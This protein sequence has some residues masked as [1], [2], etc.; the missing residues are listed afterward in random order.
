[1]LNSAALTA[2]ALAAAM[3]SVFLTAARPSNH[4][5]VECPIVTPELGHSAL[6]RCAEYA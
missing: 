5:N 3:A 2:T 6:P 1:M 4:T